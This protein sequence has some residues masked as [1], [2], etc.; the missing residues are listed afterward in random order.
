M[1]QK[2]RLGEDDLIQTDMM[3]KDFEGAVSPAQGAMVQFSLIWR[4]EARHYQLRSSSSMARDL[5]AHYWAETGFMPTIAYHLLCISVLFNGLR[6]PWKSCM[7]TR[8]SA[9]QQPIRKSGVVW[10][11]SAYLVKPGKVRSWRW[12]ISNWIRSKKSAQKSHP[13][14]LLGCKS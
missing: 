7:L 1:Y 12:L 2:V 14:H 11:W 9:L 4:L 10:A 8:L 6:I 3:L 13:E 5:T